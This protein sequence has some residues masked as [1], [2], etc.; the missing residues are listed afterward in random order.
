MT[1]IPFLIGIPVLVALIFPFMLQESRLRGILVYA[2]SGIVM[3]LTVILMVQWIMDGSETQMLYEST[4]TVDHVI[5]A[6]DIYV[7]HRV[8]E[9]K[10]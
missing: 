4:E 6:G 1:I 2:G 3:L 10:V 9:H 8:F 7:P 5:A